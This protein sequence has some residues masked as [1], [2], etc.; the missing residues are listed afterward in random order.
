MRSD[1]RTEAASRTATISLPAKVICD[2]VDWCDMVENGFARGKNGSPLTG[3]DPVFW[4]TL[5]GASLS[6][7]RG[8]RLD[9]DDSIYRFNVLPR[10]TGILK[11]EPDL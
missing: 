2:Y 1:F 9:P 5:A 8:E 3:G 10:S 11:H 4:L 7:R 6:L